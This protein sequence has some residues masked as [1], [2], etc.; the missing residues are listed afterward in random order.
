MIVR[1]RGD[2]MRAQPH[3]RPRTDIV[4]APTYADTKFEREPDDHRED[5]P[6]SSFLRSEATRRGDLGCR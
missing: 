3:W 2:D 5:G 1:R 4:T 6:A